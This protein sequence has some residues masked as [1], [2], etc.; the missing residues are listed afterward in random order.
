MV[1]AFHP[2]STMTQLYSLPPLPNNNWCAA[3]S[4]TGTSVIL[5]LTPKV[6]GGYVVEY[7][8]F[9]GH[10]SRDNTFPDPNNPANMLKWGEPL[11][12]RYYL[13]MGSKPGFAQAA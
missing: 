6:G 8:M 9:G 10:T 2:D 11:A 12:L 7:A 3:T 4:S 13:R 1:S 5:P